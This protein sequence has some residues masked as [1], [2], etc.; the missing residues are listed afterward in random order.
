M[1]NSHLIYEYLDSGLNDL[2]EDMLFK[3]LYENK[4]FRDEFY[5]M[6]KFEGAATYSFANSKVPVNVTND[7]FHNLGVSLPNNSI[8]IVEKERPIVGFLTSLGSLAMFSHFRDYL[9]A[10]LGLLIG[11]ILTA[12]IFMFNQ[13]NSNVTDNNLN[14][15]NNSNNSNNV[16]NIG[17]QYPNNTNNSNSN[18][19]IPITKSG[20]LKSDE[21]KSSDKI[22]EDGKVKS[23][24][25][26]INSVSNPNS[27]LNLT[28]KF[29]LLTKEELEKSGNLNLTEDIIKN[30]G[31]VILNS[32]NSNSD[33]SINNNINNLL[34]NDIIQTL[35]NSNNISSNNSLID[36]NTTIFNLANFINL[37]NHNKTT[38]NEQIKS[39]NIINNLT[40]E[41]R[42][43]LFKENIF[44]ID[45]Q[46]YENEKDFN[47]FTLTLSGIGFSQNSYNN[48]TQSFSNN[49]RIGLLYSVASNHYLG[50][51]L[52]NE[53]FVLPNQFDV[54]SNNNTYFIGANYKYN[55][56]SLE[57]MQGLY[58]SIG[59][60][61]NFATIGTITRLNLGLNLTPEDRLSFSVFYEPTILFNNYRNLSENYYKDNI[62]IGISYKLQ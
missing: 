50:V 38:L 62:I 37:I 41:T 12:V 58:P 33:N 32:D 4:D 3:E 53:Q 30:L 26:R 61:I 47:D 54:Y 60:A 31:M 16:N 6:V 48:P 10:F 43:K 57:L 39:I 45:T 23:N 2:N 24:R 42:E 17:S 11:G 56:K 46:I 21:I 51:D 36:N 8:K 40:N 55:I 29:K 13:N 52:G 20:E 22:D 19:I 1:S 35:N 59:T 27:Q 34:S 15:Y 5:T 14:T 28:S 18:S 25:V 7:L 9:S 44:Y 49:L